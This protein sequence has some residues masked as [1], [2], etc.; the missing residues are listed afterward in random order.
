MIEVKNLI[1]GYHPSD[2]PV[3][4]GI[5]LK[6]RRGEYVALI[7]PNGSGKTTL[8]KHLNFVILNEVK[9]LSTYRDYEILR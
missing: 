4:A 8:V 7:G 6:V 5:S 9:D 2:R 1:Y 3:L